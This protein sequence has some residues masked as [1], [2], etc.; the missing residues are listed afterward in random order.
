MVPGQAHGHGRMGHGRGQEH[1]REVLAGLARVH[2]GRAPGQALGAHAQGHVPGAL[3]IG[4][5]HVL[6][7]QGLA[8]R[9]HG[10]L[11]HA[12]RA[13]QD[14]D[15][16]PGRGHGGHEPGRGAGLVGVKDDR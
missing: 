3:Q 16:L 10:P 9:A 13:A 1:A 11:V 8:E 12:R 5:G 6:L 15:A 4:D 7:G 2:G 14:E